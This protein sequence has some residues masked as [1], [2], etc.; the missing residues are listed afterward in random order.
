V[1]LH[2]HQAK[3]LGDGEIHR[4]HTEPWV[5]TIELASCYAS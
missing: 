1:L 3:L 5:F 2:M 4:F